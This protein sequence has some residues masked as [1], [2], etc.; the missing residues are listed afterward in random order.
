LY[1][2]AGA[3]VTTSL[4]VLLSGHADSQPSRAGLSCGGGLPWSLGCAGRF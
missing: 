1:A 2:G 3:L 4:I